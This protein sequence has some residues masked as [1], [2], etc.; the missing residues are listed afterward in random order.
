MYEGREIKIVFTG[1]M[2]AGKTTAIAALSDSAPVATEVHNA[3]RASADKETTTVALDFGQIQL[4]DGLVV[5]LYG[6]PG[7]DRFNFMWQILG[8]G[9]LGVIMLLDASRVTAL[10]E[11]DTYLASFEAQAREGRLVI[12]LGRTE[13]PGSLKPADVLRRLRIDRLALPVFS[14]DVRQREDVLL[15]IEALVNLIE[16]APTEESL[17]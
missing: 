13:T 15:L 10:T 1:P 2:G 17:Q 5:R 6:T 8:T 12:G 16:A 7:Q 3:D 4:D 9:A 14:V 11:L